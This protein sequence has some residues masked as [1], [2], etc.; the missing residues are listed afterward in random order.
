[1]IK[2]T[3]II[4]CVAALMWALVL[5]SHVQT[6]LSLRQYGVTQFSFVSLPLLVPGAGLLAAVWLL[7]K[8]RH[9]PAFASALFALVTASFFY[10]VQAV[11][12][13]G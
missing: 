12:Q 6:L 11:A 10:L 13:G 9:G 5:F 1:M 7:K 3:L 8:Q 4:G 2:G